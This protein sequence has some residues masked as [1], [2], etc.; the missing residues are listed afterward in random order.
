MDDINDIHN[1]FSVA[2]VLKITGQDL[3]LKNYMSFCS[4][5]IHKKSDSKINIIIIIIQL[6]CACLPSFL[7]L[8]TRPQ[9]IPLQH[10]LETLD[11]I[12]HKKVTLQHIP[13]G[14]STKH[15][16]ECLVSSDSSLAATTN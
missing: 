2:F 14:C 12:R 10:L 1:D 9:Q 7:D 13:G 3:M 15:T 11:T 6:V 5:S 8:E 16:Q 4:I